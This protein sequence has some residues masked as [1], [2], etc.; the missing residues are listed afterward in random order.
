MVSSWGYLSK[1]LLLILRRIPWINMFSFFPIISLLSPIHSYASLQHQFNTYSP[2]CATFVLSLSLPLCLF[3]SS[4]GWAKTFSKRGSLRMKS[5]LRRL[6]FQ[7]RLEAKNVRMEKKMFKNIDVY[8]SKTPLSCQRL[9]VCVSF[10][11]V[12]NQQGM[13][14]P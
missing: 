12:A 2:C 5:Y 9:S 1:G 14:V 3:L 8:F 6:L 10:P 7:S 11:I 13:C 4:P